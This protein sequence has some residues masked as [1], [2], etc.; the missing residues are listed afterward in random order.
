M[1]KYVMLLLHQPVLWL[2]TV[3]EG[4]DECLMSGGVAEH[5]QTK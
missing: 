4:G 2:V 5:S 1:P 3:T